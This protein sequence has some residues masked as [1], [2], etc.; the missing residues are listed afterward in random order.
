M[1]RAKC[2]ACGRTVEAESDAG[3]RQVA[4]ACGAMVTLPSGAAVSATSRAVEEA[5]RAMETKGGDKREKPATRQV[6]TLGSAGKKAASSAAPIVP[7]ADKTSAGKLPIDKKHLRWIVA[8]SAVAIVA[9]VTWNFL[10]PTGWEREFGGQVEAAKSEADQLATEGKVLAA[11]RK[12]QQALRLTKGQAIHGG[13]L[14]KTVDATRAAR[15][16]LVEQ[17]RTMIDKARTAGAFVD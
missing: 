14:K 15:D 4:C 16:R 3:R 13:E 11:Y 17:N 6:F 7:A 8:M 12:Y 9:G 2:S 1:I 5:L 10:T